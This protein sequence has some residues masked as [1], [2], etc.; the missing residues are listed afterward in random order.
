MSFANKTLL[1]VILIFVSNSV[2]SQSAKEYFFDNYDSEQGLIHNY[3][4]SIYQ[5]SRNIL[6]VGSYG[7]VQA[8]NG[9]QFNVFNVAGKKENANILS[10][11]VVHAIYEDQNQNMW[12]GTENG[13]NKFNTSTGKVTKYFHE[14]DNSNSISSNNIR[15]IFQDDS[16]LLWIGT[17]GGGLNKFDEKLNKFTHFRA[18]VGNANTILSDRINTMDWDRK[19]WRISL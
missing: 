9:Y 1:V 6:W 8:F 3:V 11:T 14:P 19:W 4:L 10:N 18:D 2:N 15:A 12:F 13:L 17:Y 5:D 7:G 16:G